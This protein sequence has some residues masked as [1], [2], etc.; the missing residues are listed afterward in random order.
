M[1]FWK[2]GSFCHLGE[3]AQVGTVW[4]SLARGAVGSFCAFF[5]EAC[6][7]MRQGS[8]WGLGYRDCDGVVGIWEG[9]VR[10]ARD[11]GREI[12]RAF[13]DGFLG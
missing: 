3:V 4:H 5:G 8:S 10:G 13:G 11:I 12:F 6:E 7:D 1:P 9:S 2:V